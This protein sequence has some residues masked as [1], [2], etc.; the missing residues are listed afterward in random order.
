MEMTPTTLP[1]EASRYGR[2]Y[3]VHCTVPQKFTSI[4][5]RITFR[6]RSL[7]MA[8]MEMPA[9]FTRMSMRPKR[10]T[11]FSTRLRQSS[12]RV[13]SVFTQSTLSAQALTEGASDSSFSRLRAA[14]TTF[15][16]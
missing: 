2:A 6:S 9:L 13:T 16:P 7:N 3:L 5:A 12:S 14:I 8:R 15:A 4:S 1:F 11:V 10:S